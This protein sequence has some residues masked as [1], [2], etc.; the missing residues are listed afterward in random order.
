MVVDP[1]LVAAIKKMAGNKKIAGGLGLPFVS[2]NAVELYIRSPWNYDSRPGLTFYESICKNE[3]ELSRIPMLV[4]DLVENV[5]LIGAPIALAALGVEGPYDVLR[6][7]EAS[8]LQSF[9][10]ILQPEHIDV[11]DEIQVAVYLEKGP[12]TEVD[13]TRVRAT[14]K[15]ALEQFGV[16]EEDQPR[17]LLALGGAFKLLNEHPNPIPVVLHEI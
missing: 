4:K 2:G 11:E 8:I 6:F 1:E 16:A 10:P 13:C 12:P 17:T 15:W 7:K 3:P 14:G 9:K 5:A